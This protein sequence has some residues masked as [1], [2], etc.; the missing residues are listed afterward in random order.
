MITV[1]LLLLLVVAS[2]A[3]TEDVPDNDE[4]C[5]YLNAEKCQEIHDGFASMAKKT[6]SRIIGGNNKSGLRTFNTEA[7]TQ[8]PFELKTLVVLVAWQGQED[9]MDWVSRDEIDR[10]WN[11]LG[12]DDAIIP[13]GSIKNYTERQSYHTVTFSADVIDWQ[14]TDNTETYY[15]DKRSGMPKNGDREPHLREAFHHVLNQM[16]EESFPWE[17][18]DSDNDGWID[19]V[20]FLHTGYGAESGI[21]D[22]YTGARADDRIWS[23]ALPEGQAKW[24]SKSGMELGGYSTSSVFDGRCNQN[25]AQLGIMIHEFYH[26]LGLP[27]LYD[28]D[29]P[30]SGS[31]G[32]LGGIGIFDM[33]ACPFGANNN[34][35]H[36]GSLSPWSKLEMGFL[37]EP[38]EITQSG[39]YTARPS[40]DFPDIYA[41]KRGYPEGEM[42]LLENRQNTG[43]D[44]SLPTGG[45]LIFKID[46][47][48]DYN[49]N[50]RHGFPG[51]VNT[52]EDG[53]S[54]PSNGLHYPIALL[55]ADGDYDLEQARNN[56]DSGDFYNTPAQILGPGNGELV[57]TSDGTYPNT[58]SYVNGEIK[59]TGTTIDNFR[60]TPEGSGIFTFRVTFEGDEPVDDS[61]T[62]P[63]TQKP[64]MPPTKTPT[65][66]PTKP[67]T[68]PTNAPTKAP[69]I[70]T[71]A[72]TGKP[73][74][75]PT[76]PPTA[77]PTKN[78][79]HLP[80]NPPTKAPTTAPSD[81]PSNAPT[82]SPA[83]TNSQ[84]PS[85]EP[86]MAPIDPSDCGHILHVNITTDNFPEQTTWEIT[87]IATGK[88][89]TGY[90][91]SEDLRPKR[92]LEAYTEY[93]WKI[94]LFG[95]ETAF[96]FSIFDKGGDGLQ[97]PGSFTVEL[98]GKLI[99]SGGQF[100]NETLS[101]EFY[102]QEQE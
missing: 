54:W 26:T 20:Q 64:T 102:T 30:Y 42:L 96:S 53:Q 61:P 56:G 99:L 82:I 51:Q 29:Q 72:P 101:M 10:L 46:G 100:A 5:R 7:K 55:Q 12:V 23:H 69:V 4:V 93:G 74:K 92:A 36:P 65:A 33:M 75:P 57:S 86:T 44:V 77:S 16:D 58:D 15:A 85:D 62:I 45:M 88:Y 59:V 90:Q 3:V 70:P 84:A 79:T 27:D 50:R 83:P 66:Y 78:P 68:V 81:A 25:I 80:T 19:H 18:Y 52:P 13:T 34:Q 21:T 39:I 41:I 95:R 14:V 35:M 47:T 48:I 43:H 22:C 87:S 63:P 38:I 76:D 89:L 71:N 37:E 8:E 40:N 60:E 73:S 94:C 67:P 98:D 1:L 28:R 97:P 6:R 32:G 24:T 91:S 31:R 11:G 2:R 17:D 9:R 49:G